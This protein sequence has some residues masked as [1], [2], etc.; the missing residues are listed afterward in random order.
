MDKEKIEVVGRIQNYLLSNI[1]N[2][3]DLN[4]LSKELGYSKYYAIKLFK[5]MMGTTP[6]EYLRDLRLTKA[7]ES[8][9]DTDSKVIDVALENGF[10]S[11]DG[12]TR[13]FSRKF[14]MTPSKYSSEKPPIPYFIFYPIQNYYIL[15]SGGNIMENEKIS[16]TVTATFVKRPARKL[17]LL[18][19]K[20]TID[21]DYLSY[22]EEMGCE[23]EGLLNSIS[24]KYDVS[25]LMIL[26]ESL[27]KD[28]YSNTA[29]GIEVPLSYNKPIPKNYDI[30]ELEECTM[31][32]FNSAP[33]DNEED[34]CIAINIVLDA[35]RNY[36]PENYGYRYAYELAPQI[37]YGA[38]TKTGARYAVPVKKI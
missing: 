35:V 12:F 1:D 36:N 22:C 24:E 10:D 6:M 33:Y 3:I 19:A 27:C 7:A 14:G 5:D 31:M 20:D 28:G 18:R 38:Y 21:G 8:L 2:N 32:Y 15:N 25:G 9:R 17:I 30:I 13:A 4:D 11:H 26:P 34:F 16:R 29:S 37:N 23:W